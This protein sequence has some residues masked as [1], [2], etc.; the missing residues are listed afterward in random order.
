[1]M[2]PNIDS[3]GFRVFGSYW[4]ALELPRHLFHFSP[5]SLKYMAN[6]AGLEALSV[7]LDREPFIENSVRYIV[8]AGLTKVGIRRRPLAN[9]AHPSLAKRIVSKVVRNTILPLASLPM[10]L[11]GPGESI[12]AVFQRPL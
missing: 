1:M 9:A 8:D 6:S 5:Q 12:H 10:R 11:A 2:S 4:F 7:K 3:A